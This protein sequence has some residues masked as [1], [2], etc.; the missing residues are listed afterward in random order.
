MA[1]SKRMVATNDVAPGLV[2]LVLRQGHFC[3]WY[4]FA[5][6]SQRFGFSIRKGDKHEFNIRHSSGSR[7]SS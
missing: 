5:L 6:E 1:P 7:A 2:H 4:G 3:R